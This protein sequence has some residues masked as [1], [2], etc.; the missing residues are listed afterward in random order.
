MSTNHMITCP[1]GL[2]IEVRELRSKDL[3]L[4]SNRK[5]QRRN[6]HLDRVMEACVIEVMNPGP[7][8]LNAAG[9]LNW[10][11][12][13]NGDRIHALLQL[14]SMSYD[15]MVSFE[16][17]CQNKQ[18][19]ERVYWDIDLSDIEMR[20]FTE[21]QLD[22]FSSSNQFAVTLPG[23]GDR[24]WLKFLLGE[25]E[26]LLAKRVRQAREKSRRRH[27]SYIM[28]SDQQLSM[29]HQ[30]VKIEGM[31][32]G[33]RW[34]KRLEYVEEMSASDQRWLELYLL[35]NLP[36]VRTQMTEYCDECGKEQ[37]LHLPL[38]LIVPNLKPKVVE[39]IS[40]SSQSK[41]SSTTSGHDSQV[42]MR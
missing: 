13:Y 42:E 21:E 36:G 37:E 11:K 39:T 17:P 25:D 8:E 1:T 9:K 35:D 30:I 3:A 2:D 18:C 32:D 20:P 23:S 41:I 5:L 14:F 19:R 29:A 22:N 26:Q 6:L 31:V 38:D 12:V 34:P 27:S 10:Q 40:S 24:L 7:Y 4:L 15:P 16:N 33:D 28:P